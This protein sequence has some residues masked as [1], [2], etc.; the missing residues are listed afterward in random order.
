ML[1]CWLTLSAVV[2]SLISGIGRFRLYLC[3]CFSIKNDGCNGLLCRVTYLRARNK[4]IW[5]RWFLARH[6]WLPVRLIRGS[7]L[8]G[9]DCSI[10]LKR[11][12][13]MIIIVQ[14]RF[15]RFTFV[16][17][18]IPPHASAGAEYGIKNTNHTRKRNKRKVKESGAGWASQSH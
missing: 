4:P 5:W 14:I 8:R 3:H 16:F 10:I 13:V 12:T 11:R 18:F 1:F 2:G 6:E 7:D 15:F 17:Y 9:K